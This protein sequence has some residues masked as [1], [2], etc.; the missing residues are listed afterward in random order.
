[1]V[2]LQASVVRPMGHALVVLQ[3]EQVVQPDCH[4]RLPFQVPEHPLLG[5]D[6]IAATSRCIA[7]YY[8][9]FPFQSYL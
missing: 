8:G 4:G 5:V 6:M 7:D 9:D 3:L 1:M 2:E